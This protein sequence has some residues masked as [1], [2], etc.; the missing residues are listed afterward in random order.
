MPRRGKKHG[1]GVGPASTHSPR[2]RATPSFSKEVQNVSTSSSSSREPPVLDSKVSS[3][4][5]K[6]DPPW[7]DSTP[8]NFPADMR[9]EMTRT[10]G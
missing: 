9:G 10:A 6:E 4:V 5:L 1:K 3:G 2:T 8:T 7:A